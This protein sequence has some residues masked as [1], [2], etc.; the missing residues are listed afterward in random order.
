MAIHRLS[1]RSDKIEG[2]GVRYL[3]KFT[4]FRECCH[5]SFALRVTAG[6]S[7][8]EILMESYAA[9]DNNK[10][11]RTMRVRRV[12]AFLGSTRFVLPIQ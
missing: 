2:E 5:F 7:K 9:T 6:P 4:A 3:S 11:H 12:L 8:K 1:R 10:T